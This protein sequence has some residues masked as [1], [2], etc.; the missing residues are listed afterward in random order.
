MRIIVFFDLP[1]ASENER[2]AATRFRNFLVA[3]GY[4]MLQYSVYVRLCGGID[5]VNDAINRMKS[6][7]PN[8][9]SIRCMTV[10]EKQYSS[11]KIIFGVKKKQ[12]KPIETYQ[13]SFL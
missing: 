4:Y 8:T 10:T 6:A 2:R 12:E 7:A 3:D 1:V 9:G 13:I 5:S 11:M